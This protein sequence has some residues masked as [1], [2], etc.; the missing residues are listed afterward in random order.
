MLRQT[1]LLGFV[2]ILILGGVLSA[3]PAVAGAQGKP[4]PA[5]NGITQVTL[6]KDASAVA[7]GRDLLLYRRTFA[8]GAD[9]GAHPA[10]GPVVL[11]VDS[12]YIGFKVVKGEALVTW[13]TSLKTEGL[14]AGSEVKLMP[15]DEVSYDQ[16]VVHEVRNIG[17]T[18]AITL[19]S[20]LNPRA[21][22]T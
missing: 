10:P 16:G 7:P 1:Q 22:A 4:A 11:Y 12:G 13:G 21:P 15:G 8:P 14:P 2:F 6:G 3:V 20:R 17:V 5:A 19:E 18:P 9:S